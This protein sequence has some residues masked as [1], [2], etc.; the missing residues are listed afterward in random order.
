MKAAA[1]VIPLKPAEGLI[2]RAAR[3]RARF[4]DISLAQLRQRELAWIL[5]IS[6]GYAANLEHALRVNCVTF[7]NQ[8]HDCVA[9][10]I[11]AVREA[12]DT[13]RQAL[14]TIAKDI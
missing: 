2:K 9:E 4:A 7:T 12:T 1:N 10:L 3:R 13:Y 8:D 14:N 11:S 6:E 5:Y